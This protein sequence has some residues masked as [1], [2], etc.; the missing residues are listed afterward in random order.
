MILETFWLGSWSAYVQDNRR[1][2]SIDND[3]Y[4]G[5]KM[6]KTSFWDE[7]KWLCL[8]K[9][10]QSQSTCDVKFMNCA[11]KNDNELTD[12]NS[13]VNMVTPDHYHV[14]SCDSN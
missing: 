7:L 3:S 12:Y 1:Q 13:W 9:K 10:Y 5:L 6:P 11:H 2:V 4:L 14:E 8:N